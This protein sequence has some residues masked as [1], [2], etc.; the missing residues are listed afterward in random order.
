[1][2]VVARALPRIAAASLVASLSLYPAP[3]AATLAATPTS[4]SLLCQRNGRSS[5][6]SHE[7]HNNDLIT[8]RI[9]WSDDDCSIELRATGD[10][11]FNADF[12]DIISVANGGSVDLTEVDGNTTRRLRLRPD[13]RG[14]TRTYS[15]NG[16]EQAWDDNA[17]RWLADLLIDFD[18]RSA[19]GVDY[20]FPLL[21]GQGGARAVLD[22][23]EKM[24]GDY[25]RSVYL[26]R[27]VDTQRLSDA[28]YQRVVE[29]TARTMSS[30]YEMSR[31]LRSVADRT[32]L[33]N[34]AMRTSYIAAVKRMS[35][36]YERSR[37]L[38]TIF[39][40]STISHEVAAAAVRAAGTFSS[41]YERSR[42]LLAAIESKA[43]SLDDVIPVLETVARSSS[44]YEKARVM[45]AVASRW[46]LSGDARKSYLRTADTIRS[47]YENRRV[48]S[49]L[50][51]QE[52]R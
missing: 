16:R 38:Q 4:A 52:A 20:R 36:D 25:A 31:V 1:M 35:S 23:T 18:R 10:L 51:K 27:L 26:R 28:E 13:G 12:T 47:D 17:R 33:D 40:K 6:S 22:E 49:A 45:L 44:D 21:F 15:V 37:V 11:K 32:S 5:E 41:D 42:V 39:A 8:W 50:V 48:L 7:Q 19:I 3:A 34:E 24:T 43:L 46:T 29:V 9:R 14:M 2:L 30:D